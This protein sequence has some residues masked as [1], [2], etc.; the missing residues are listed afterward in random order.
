MLKR[1]L[2]SLTKPVWLRGEPLKPLC[3]VAASQRI[4]AAKLKGSSVALPAADSPLFVNCLWLGFGGEFLEAR[5]IPERIEHRIKP[6]QGRSE[7]RSG[8]CAK[9]RDGE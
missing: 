3:W 8:E 9:V 6:E 1:Y 4:R 5:I 7:R 2:S